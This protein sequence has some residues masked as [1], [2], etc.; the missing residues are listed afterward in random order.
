MT[1]DNAYKLMEL[2]VGASEEE[3]HKAFKKLAKKHH[4]DSG[5]SEHNFKILLEAKETLLRKEEKK[6]ILYGREYTES[7]MQEIIKNYKAELDKMDKFFAERTKIVTIRMYIV[8]AFLLKWL[9]VNII[10]GYSNW[11]FSII[12][13]IVFGILMWMAPTISAMRDVYLKNKK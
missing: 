7:E 9:V 3:I 11:K 5:G 8:I 10:F 12:S 2:S 6:Y 4:P 1:K 13:V